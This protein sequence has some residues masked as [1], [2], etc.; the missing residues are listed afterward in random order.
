MHNTSIF[1]A[2]LKII[3][4][5]L[6]YSSRVKTRWWALKRTNLQPTIECISSSVIFL[7]YS[8]LVMTSAV[9][10]SSERS[11][12]SA[13]YGH[14]TMV[15][16]QHGKHALTCPKHQE[17]GFACELVGLILAGTWRDFAADFTSSRRGH[18]RAFSWWEQGSVWFL[19]CFISGSKRCK[20]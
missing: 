6:M 8:F 16:W 4:A 10:H 2:P 12:V 14:G 9:A 3:N 18:R 7:T 1:R 5:E 15:S 17:L 13:D 11:R 20:S 19:F